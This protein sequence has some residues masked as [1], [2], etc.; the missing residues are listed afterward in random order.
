MIAVNSSLKSMDIIY[1]HSS[2]YLHSVCRIS[3]I[4]MHIHHLSN[5]PN[6]CINIIWKLFE[7]Q[8]KHWQFGV[9]SS[10][11]ET[12][13]FSILIVLT[14]LTEYKPCIT[15]ATISNP[16][17]IVH[18]R[19]VFQFK[20]FGIWKIERGKTRTPVTCKWNFKWINWIRWI[21][22]YFSEFPLRFKQF[23]IQSTCSNM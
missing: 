22:S 19:P 3:M 14:N 12:F 20:Y 10:D 9:R 23:D 15:S 1:Y 21:E 18:M 17:S 4:Q 13:A 2:I 16:V 5:V 6:L 11:I 7:Q 8:I